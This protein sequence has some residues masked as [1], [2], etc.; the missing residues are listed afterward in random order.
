MRTMLHMFTSTK[1]SAEA[2]YR[3]AKQNLKKKKVQSR[4]GREDPEGGGEV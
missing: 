1:N 2:D 3:D 4:T